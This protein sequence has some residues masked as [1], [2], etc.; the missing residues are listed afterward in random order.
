MK[1]AENNILVIKL[2]YIGDVL[3]T[4]PVF[5]ALRS[6]YPE[7]RI[8]ALVNKGTEAVLTDNPAIDEVLT[9]ERHVNRIN[10]LMIQLRLVRRLRSYHFNYALELTNSDRGAMLSFLSGADKRIGYRPRDKMKRINRRFL[11]TDLVSADGRQHIVEYHLAMLRPL[12]CAVKTR[13]LRL[14]WKDADEAGLK[15]VFETDKI[16]VDGQFVVMHPFSRVPSKA[17]RADNYAAVCDHLYETWG[18]RTILVCGNDNS[19]KNFLE[20]IKTRCQCSPVHLGAKLTLKQLA[21]LV[22]RAILFFGIDSGPMHIA[23]AVNTPVIALFGPS[24]K[25]RWGPWGDNHQVI[26]K[27]WPCVPCGKKGCDGRGVSNCLEELTIDEVVPVLD[28]A[29]RSRVPNNEKQSIGLRK[30]D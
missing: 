25:F 28:A 15:H 20:K 27:S 10:D 7:A 13:Q 16:S 22:S 14:Y 9:L 18:I 23:M 11:L 1:T 30:N 4:T 12:D 8:V 21:V 29:L 3:L 17:W 6:N 26:Q 19:E 24:R 2:R 5:E